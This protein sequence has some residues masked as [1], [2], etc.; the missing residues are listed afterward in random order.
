MRPFA[1]GKN[2]GN[3]HPMDSVILSQGVG[4]WGMRQRMDGRWPL[5]G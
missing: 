2:C 5:L 3:G 4:E 1:T